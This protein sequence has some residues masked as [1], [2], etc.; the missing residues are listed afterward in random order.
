MSQ[1][2]LVVETSFGISR[3]TESEQLERLEV[4]DFLSEVHD[5]ALVLWQGVTLKLPLKHNKRQISISVVDLGNGISI[6]M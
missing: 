4:A 6:Y 5:E 2:V 3:L 1:N